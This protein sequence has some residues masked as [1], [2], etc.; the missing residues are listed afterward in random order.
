MTWGL[1][2]LLVILF[3]CLSVLFFLLMPNSMEY[4]E[5]YFIIVI[6]I[7]FI[8]LIF[9]IDFDNPITTTVY[10]AKTETNK[11][12]VYDVPY[13]DDTGYSNLM[14]LTFAGVYNGK[15][16]VN[17]TNYLDTTTFNYDTFTDASILGG[18][19]KVTKLPN[20]QIQLDITPGTS[21]PIDGFITMSLLCTGSQN[22]NG[23]FQQV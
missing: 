16:P 5:T 10:C 13:N 21:G 6:I 19:I 17:D 8:I 14:T 12:L 3:I 11:T 22:I 23:K 15:S 4:I 1:A 7:L 2:I 9:A 18:A 20:Y